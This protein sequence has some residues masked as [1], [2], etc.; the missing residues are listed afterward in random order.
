MS[1]TTVAFFMDHTVVM[2]TVLSVIVHSQIYKQSDYQ[3]IL[4]FSLSLVLIF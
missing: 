3:L 4:L 2:M 1:L